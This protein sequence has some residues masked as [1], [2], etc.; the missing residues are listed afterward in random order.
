MLAGTST[1]E[2]KAVSLCRYVFLSLLAIPVTTGEAA[3]PQKRI[4]GT[5]ECD[6]RAMTAT[7]A[8]AERNFAT[9]DL[10]RGRIGQAGAAD[11]SCIG[12]TLDRAPSNVTVTW[13]NQSDKVR[14]GVTPTR[15]YE[16]PNGERCR[17]YVVTM[18]RGNRRER[19]ENT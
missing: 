4:F 6:A 13:D 19:L 18:G 15:T 11:N 8:P 16:A 9:G 7:K 10:V 14:F 12:W 5:H 2:R 3:E 1:L 17:D